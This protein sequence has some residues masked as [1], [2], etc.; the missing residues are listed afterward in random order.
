MKRK[1]KHDFKEPLHAWIDRIIPYYVNRP[2]DV[3][4]LKDLLH[5]VS[6]ISYIHGSNDAQKAFIR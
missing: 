2:I 6:V 5:E 1:L 3:E 4:E